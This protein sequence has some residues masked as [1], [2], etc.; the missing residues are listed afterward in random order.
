MYN[1]ECEVWSVVW[2]VKCGVQSVEC[3]VWGVDCGV[4]DTC[5]HSSQSLSQSLVHGFLC[6]ISLA[7]QPPFAHSLV[8]LT[9]STLH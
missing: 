5:D 7:S 1:V 2:N 4:C 8:H 9:T 3:K 6:F